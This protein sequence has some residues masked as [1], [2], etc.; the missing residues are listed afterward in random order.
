MG[1]VVDVV[2]TVTVIAITARAISEFQIR[3]I[4]IRSTADSAFMMVGPLT[5]GIPIAIGPVRIGLS[6]ML[7]LC[8]S[9]RVKR[10]ANTE[11]TSTN[12]KYIFNV[13]TKKEKI[14]Q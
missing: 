6:G 4:G 9:F 3:I 5:C 10:A 12:T 2:H 1:V 7:L 13:G 8:S 14:I 11:R